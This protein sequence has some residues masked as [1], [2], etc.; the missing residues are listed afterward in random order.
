VGNGSSEVAERC[1]QAT[2]QQL[3]NLA[4]DDVVDLGLQSVPDADSGV[5]G[6]AP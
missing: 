5:V 3:V 2:R 6:R 1:A 4:L